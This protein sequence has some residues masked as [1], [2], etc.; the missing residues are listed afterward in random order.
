M[1]TSR[2]DLSG[3]VPYDPFQGSQPAAPVKIA[4][5]KTIKTLITLG[6]IL[7]ILAIALG[8]IGITG[9]IIF[10]I[11]GGHRFVGD[12]LAVDL[13][14][15]TE[16][17]IKERIPS[18]SS[19]YSTMGICKVVSGPEGAHWNLH[20]NYT[21]YGYGTGSVEVTPYTFTTDTAGRYVFS[22]VHTQSGASDFRLVPASR[23]T[24]WMVI[25]CPLAFFVFGPAALATLIPGRTMRAK[26][27]RYQ[28]MTVPPEWADPLVGKEVVKAPE[29]GM[30]KSKMAAGLLGIFLGAYGIHNF[31]LGYTGK[32]LTQLLVTVL[33]CGIAG[34]GMWVWG[35]VEGILILTGG[36]DRDAQGI[37]LSARR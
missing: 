20:A 34:I 33:T 3:H 21:S 19:Y 12:T 8:L 2:Q 28:A 37:F 22:G 23:P 16:Y 1:P 6:T 4:K 27:K 5:P 14:A 9:I 31:Y 15:N 17:Q 26:A 29:S 30:G 10:N 32:A 35:L 11:L 25:G 36:I 24:D 18:G 13:E 7:G